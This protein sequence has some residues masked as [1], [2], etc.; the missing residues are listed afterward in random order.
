MTATVVGT[1][2]ERDLTFTTDV[3]VHVETPTEMS[4]TSLPNKTTYGVGESL[5]TLGMRV[6]LVYED[7]TTVN[8][9]EDDYRIRFDSNSPGE[10]EVR[11]V[12]TIEGL[13]LE[14]RF[15]VTVDGSITPTN[16]TTSTSTTSGSSDSDG[17]S[18]GLIIG[19]VAGVVV[20]VAVVVIVIVVSK[21]KKKAE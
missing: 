11:V 1:D 7:G 21:K 15:T 13:D 9:D 18:I 2:T 6:A 12:S 4:V 10:K 17:P 16:P 19:I 8:M 3:I 20:V 14:A 5:D